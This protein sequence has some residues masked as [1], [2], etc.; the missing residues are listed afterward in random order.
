MDTSTPPVIRG[1][2]HFTLP[3]GDLALAER[4]YVGLLGLSLV[5]RIDAEAFAA[6]VPH[7]ARELDNNN[8]NSPLH[9]ELRCGGLD[10]HLF[11][12]RGAPPSELRPHPH[13]AFELDASEFQRCEAHLRARGVPYDGPRRLGPPGQASLYFPDPFGNLLEYTTSGHRGDIPI[14]PPDLQYLAAALAQTSWPQLD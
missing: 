7:R 6:H 14:G 4:F 8:N 1:V 9:L 10:L 11:L 13:L 12:Q 3:I 2:S 5:R